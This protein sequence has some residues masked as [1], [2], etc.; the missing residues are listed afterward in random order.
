M[1]HTDFQQ[2]ND[3]KVGYD[4]GTY[5]GLKYVNWIVTAPTNT[6]LT[7]PNGPNYITTGSALGPLA[8]GQI[9]LQMPDN[10]D[11]L[12]VS[13]LRWFYSCSTVGGYQAV[14]CTVRVHLYTLYIYEGQN[15]YYDLVYKP[16]LAQGATNTFSTWDVSSNIFA[17]E[18]MTF[19]LLSAENPVNTQFNI[20][21]FDYD[22]NHWK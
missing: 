14:A 15:R 17:F 5:N 22:A 20:D 12:D 1:F 3:L 18:H 4:V 16:N 6:L 2:Y 10:T 8:K 19:E 13:P 21:N 9:L 7:V 11:I